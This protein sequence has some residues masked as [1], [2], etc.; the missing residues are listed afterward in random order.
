MEKRTALWMIVDVGNCVWDADV[1]AGGGL[2]GL[3]K[4]TREVDVEIYGNYEGEWNGCLG[5]MTVRM[6]L[7]GV[8]CQS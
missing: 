8:I 4:K 3:L 7:A 2:G 6:V 5:A 1:F